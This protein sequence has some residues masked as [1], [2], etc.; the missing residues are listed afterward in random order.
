MCRHFL[1]FRISTNYWNKK[2]MNTNF[3]YYSNPVL[4][5][6]AVARSTQT[7]IAF[8]L[9][10]ANPQHVS[11]NFRSHTYKLYQQFG[12]RRCGGIPTN[13]RTGCCSDCTSQLRKATHLM[14][15]QQLGVIN[16]VANNLNRR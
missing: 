12:V 7:L 5:G 6:S 4:V 8:L 11:R 3:K 10:L 9:A 1:I 2:A 15:L 14:S 13:V 16:S